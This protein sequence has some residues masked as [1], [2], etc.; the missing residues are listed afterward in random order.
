VVSEVP[1]TID[2]LSEVRAVI[3]ERGARLGVPPDRIADFVLAVDELAV[4]SIQHGGGHAVLRLWP[5]PSQLICEVHDLGTLHP[6]HTGRPRPAPGQLAGRGLWL[7]E[8]LC[9][10]IEIE[11]TAGGTT[12]RA[13]IARTSARS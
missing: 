9:D 13:H 2:I 12:V 7:A 5:T 11:S 10:L 8:Q 1:L 6:P 3:G 4:N